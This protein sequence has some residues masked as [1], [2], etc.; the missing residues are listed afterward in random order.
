MRCMAC[1]AEM[2]LMNAIEDVTMPVRG[3]EHHAYMCSK[4][5]ETEQRLVL[6]KRAEQTEATTATAPTSAPVGPKSTSPNLM[7]IAKSFVRLPRANGF[8]FAAEPRGFRP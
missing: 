4:C 2:I 3:F 6:N 7:Q 5:D 8:V 1:G